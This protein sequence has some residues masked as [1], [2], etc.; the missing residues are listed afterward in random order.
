MVKKSLF[1]RQ[2]LFFLIGLFC[3]NLLFVGTGCEASKQ[4]AERKRQEALKI[5]Q[6][7]NRLKALLTDN[8]RT[9]EEKERDLEEI[10]K[11]NLTDP[12]VVNLIRQVEEKLRKEKEERERQKAAAEEERKRKEEEERKRQEALNQTN[13]DVKT[14]ISIIFDEIVAA[15]VAKN[16]TL[17][18]QKINEGL[19]FFA[20]ENTPVLIIIA[21]QGNDKDY[22]EPT[23]ARKYLEYLKDKKANK[24]IIENIVFD[25][26]G[27]ITELELRKK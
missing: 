11:L 4:E 8:T 25:N 12:E 27:K 3:L 17:A 5:E 16:L 23:T 9:I 15:S 6:A 18:N 22:D 1:P 10:K 24:N 14:R 20:A 2:T 13:L 26:A 21:G 7:K 19:T